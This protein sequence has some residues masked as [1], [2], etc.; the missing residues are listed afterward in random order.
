MKHIARGCCILP[1]LLTAAGAVQADD[2]TTDSLLGMVTD[3]KANA[4]F[5]YRYENVD[6]DN[7]NRT[8]SA[9]T[10]PR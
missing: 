9:N 7:F 5:R 3:G 1:L 8:A 4:D 2:H 6:Q 10:L